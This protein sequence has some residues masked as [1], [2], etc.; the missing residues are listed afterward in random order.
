MKMNKLLLL[1]ASVLVMG[2]SVA[3][4]ADDHGM[5]HAETVT[6]ITKTVDEDG[7]EHCLD[8]YGE[9]IE[10]PAEVEGEMETEVEVEVEAE[11]DTETDAE[12]ESD[13]AY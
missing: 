10:C 11:A 9:E 8:E 12:M 4:I 1:T 5:G 13:A 7:V 6:E 3:A 2:F